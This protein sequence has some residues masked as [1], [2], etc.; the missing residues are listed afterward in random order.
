MLISH[1]HLSAAAVPPVPPVL[2][3]APAACTGYTIVAYGIAEAG[4][5]LGHPI[6]ASYSDCCSR[7]RAT[8]GCKAWTYHNTSAK[9]M[10]GECWLMP[11]PGS[12]HGNGVISGIPPPPPA[13]PPPPPL[14]PLPPPTRPPPLGF[15]PHVVFVLTDDQD[16]TQD[17]MLAMPKTR[18]LFGLGGARAHSAH[19]QLQGG[20][21][22]PVG[23]KALAMHGCASDGGT[24]FNLSRA[25]VATPICCPSR[26]SYLTGQYIH[27]TGTRQNSLRMGCSDTH[28]VAEKEPRA[29]PAYLGAAANY[30]A[31]FWGKYLNAYNNLSHV[32]TGWAEWCALQ[33]NSRYYDYALSVNGHAEQHGSNYATDYLTDLVANRSQ[34]Y[35]RRTLSNVAEAASRPLLAVV[36]TPAPHRPAQPAP[37]YMQSFTDLRAPRT[38]SWNYIGTDK[39]QF[40]SGL[41][42]MDNTTATY[43]DHIWRRR[44]RSLQSVDDLVAGLFDAVR[45]SPGN[46]M[47][48]TVFIYSRLV[49]LR[50][51]FAI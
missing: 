46:A 23:G 22:G 10:P 17:S 49:L 20:G 18:S 24:C 42:P 15:A 44:L 51:V 43:S 25:Y 39:H 29:Y 26:S 32:P 6:V 5:A 19:E 21:D 9:T 30:R 8:K 3:R 50:R 31:G 38:P 40:L 1:V 37:Q 27:N 4:S 12:A 2:A 7:C 16:I 34:A 36:H 48:R 45:A 35:I 13:P 47:D 11:T 28:W 33:G 41:R 14:P